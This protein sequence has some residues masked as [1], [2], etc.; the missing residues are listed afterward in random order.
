MNTFITTLIESGTKTVLFI[1]GSIVLL[2]LVLGIIPS[3]TKTSLT[4]GECSIAVVQIKGDIEGYASVAQDEFSFL[5]SGYTTNPDALEAVL[6][7]IENDSSID[8]VL[9]DIDSGGGS[10]IG[11]ERMAE[12]V[13]ALDKP[14]VALIGDVGASAAYLISSA[15]DYI[16]ASPFS[17]VGS[18]GVTMSYLSYA[19]QNADSGVEYVALTSAPYKDYGNENK[20]LTQE[21]RGLLERELTIAHKYFVDLVTFYREFESADVVDAVADGATRAGADALD[22]GLVDELGGV[23][24]VKAYFAQQLGKEEKDITLCK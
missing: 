21:E 10:P 13:Y 12:Q 7:E 15:A 9:F 2:I 24:A 20:D 18:I 17:S 11:G 16:I 6:K 5:S 23:D 3:M 14:T 4:G 19:Q 8:G 22:A 1:M